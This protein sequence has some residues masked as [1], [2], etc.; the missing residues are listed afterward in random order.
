MHL[1]P[2]KVELSNSNNVFPIPEPLEMKKL[3]PKKAGFRSAWILIT[4]G[5]TAFLIVPQ[6]FKI[7]K[8]ANFGC[9]KWK[10]LSESFSQDDGAAR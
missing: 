7:N 4:K 3:V 5:V 10:T 1:N 6:E 9:I 8:A 2:G